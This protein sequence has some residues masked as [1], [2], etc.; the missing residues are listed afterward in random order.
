MQWTSNSSDASS[1]DFSFRQAKIEH[2]L[3]RAEEC[4]A[5]NRYKPALEILQKA[6]RIDPHDKR[7][8][9]LKRKLD[10][11]QASVLAVTRGFSN[12]HSSK[13]G[14]IVL[15]VDQDERVLSSVASSLAR[16]GF[17]G[18]GASSFSEALSVLSEIQPHLIISE[19]NFADGPV[20]FDLYFWIRNNMA[21]MNV[22]FVFLATR[23]TR[24]MLIAGK[25][26]GV[27]EFVLKPL[28]EDV[29]MATAVHSLSRRKM[30]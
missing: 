25:R 1:I 8:Q 21:L 10:D 9:E 12:G 15:V 4:F 22:P 19:I 28:D 24:E 20:G 27:D 23:V 13:R 29:L 16:Y 17:T 14:E 7:A 2:Y 30:K 18:M 5:M 6:F 11:A 3:C 26:M